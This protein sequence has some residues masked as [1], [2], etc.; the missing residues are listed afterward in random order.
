MSVPSA[1]AAGPSLAPA[2]E[3]AQ[4]DKDGDIDMHAASSSEGDSEGSGAPGQP[5]KRRRV[6]GEDTRQLAQLVTPGGWPMGCCLLSF[7]FLQPSLAA[8]PL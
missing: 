3:Q 7:L 4:A 6:D 1:E 5:R 2:A 8:A